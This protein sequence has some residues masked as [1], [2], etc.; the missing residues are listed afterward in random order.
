MID[1]ANRGSGH[2]RAD[3]PE[4][5]ATRAASRRV[6]FYVDICGFYESRP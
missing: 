2:Q 4:L 1:E 3:Q 6:S 5:R